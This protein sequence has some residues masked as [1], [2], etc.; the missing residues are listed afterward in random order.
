MKGNSTAMMSENKFCKYCRSNGDHDIFSCPNVTCNKC[1]R[2]GH[3]D[4]NCHSVPCGKCGKL[5]HTTDKCFSKFCTHCGVA[6]HSTQQC[7]A[8]NPCGKCGGFGHGAQTCRLTT[9]LTEKVQEAVRIVKKRKQEDSDL[10]NSISSLSSSVSTLSLEDTPSS[11]E[12]NMP[13]G[14]IFEDERDFEFPISTKSWGERMDEEDQLNEQRKHPKQ[15]PTLEQ[16]K[17]SL[18][19][20][21][22]QEHSRKAN[23]SPST[24]FLKDSDKTVKDTLTFLAHNPESLLKDPRKLNTLLTMMCLLDK[25]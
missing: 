2:K 24:Q 16:I 23:V 4:R 12:V 9:E 21:I 22:T 5:T 14:S 6:G 18:G 1:G 20:L 25:Y 7:F 11:S 8:I 17:E 15:E 19:N 10:E 13:A 3:L